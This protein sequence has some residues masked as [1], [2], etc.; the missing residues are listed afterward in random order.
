MTTITKFTIIKIINSD[1][2][3]NKA[4]MENRFELTQTENLIC[5]S[6]LG[7]SADV[8]VNASSGSKRT[9]TLRINLINIRI[10][11]IHCK[12]TAKIDKNKI[13]KEIH[14]SARAVGPTSESH[15]FRCEIT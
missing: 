1:D 10:T 13:S 15:R 11:G 6:Q 7:N 14:Y 4:K 8:K 2:N 9:E 12:T 5:D 3:T